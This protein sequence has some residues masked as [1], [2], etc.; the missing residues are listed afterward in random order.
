M[1]MSATIGSMPNKP[2]TPVSTFRIPLELKAAAATKAR[3]EGTDLTAVIVAALQV[4]VKG[5]KK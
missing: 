2:K 1:S 5:G 3:D 4:Y